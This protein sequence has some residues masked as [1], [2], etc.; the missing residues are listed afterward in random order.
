MS[1]HSVLKDR[2]VMRCQR[3]G[4]QLVRSDSDIEC[5][6]CGAIHTTDGR[7]ETINAMMKLMMQQPEVDRYAVGA[8]E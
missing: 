4:G 6:Q 3:C 2:R 7:L 5:L 1:I 8:N